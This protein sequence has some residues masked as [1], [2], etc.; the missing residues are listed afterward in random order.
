MRIRIV[1]Q[2]GRCVSVCF[3]ALLAALALDALGID[4]LMRRADAA[5]YRAKAEGRNRCCQAWS[6]TA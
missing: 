3:S 1:T 2:W 5:L 4:D 6:E